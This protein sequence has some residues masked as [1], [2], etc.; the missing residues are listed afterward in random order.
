M[1]TL[2]YV[3]V[4]EFD[5]VLALDIPIER[6]CALFAALC[7]INTLY[8]IM[9]A[10]SGHIGTSFS[11]LDLMCWIFLN[12]LG[13]QRPREAHHND[14]FF[15][16]K[17]HDVPAKYSAL[18]GLRLLDFDLIHKL[19]RLGG[20]PGH[21]DISIPHMYTNTGSLGMGISKA[22]GMALARRLQGQPGRI[23][24]L[25]GDGELQEGQFWES[26]QPT[27]NQGL[28][29]ITVVVDH[30]K[31]QSDTWV[32][33]V[34]DLGALERKI[35]AF[36]WYVERC[37]GHD[38]TA[39]QRTFAQLNQITDRPKLLIA[40]TIKGKGVSFMEHTAMPPGD[41]RLYPYH[42][43]APDD[44][45]Y[46]RAAEEL[47]IGA[48]R[49][50]S[51][52][53]QPA[54][55]LE[56]VQQ[57]ARSS[58]NHLQRLVAAY[59]DALVKAAEHNPKLVALDADLARDTGLIP[60][61]ARFPERFFECGIAEQDMVSQAGGMALQGLLP[62]VHSFACFLSTRPNEQI[63]NNATE[64]TKIIY[65]GSLAG[66]IPG[67]PGHSH[68]SVRDISA[69][70][71]IPNLLLI[72]PSCEQEVALALDFCINR[73]AESCY[74]RL[75]SVPC[76]IPFSLPDDYELEYG[77]GIELTP[78]EDAL[79]FSYGPVMLAQAVY[80]ARQLAEEGIGLKVINLPWLNR[81]DLE[82]LQATLAGYRQV[83]TLDNHYINGGQGQFLASHIAQ[84]KLADPPRV[85][86]FG[87]QDI[88]VCGTNDEV[89]RA[90]RLD[91]QSLSEQIA[92]VLAE[93]KTR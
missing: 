41:D 56:A 11:S 30:N 64:L 32:A 9:R 85:H 59:A 90:H 28:H 24:V 6:R 86:Q 76:A 51:E 45:T 2:Y 21:P 55:T 17:G 5:R 93:R 4:D 58:G 43:G 77:R 91:A 63:Y 12:E 72:E 50:L 73:T 69:L 10:G 16:S 31:L 46:A 29:E 15:S 25:T 40:D 70:G 36:G 35:Q 7:R 37:D 23:L 3:P 52:M 87:L 19:R 78:G 57:P 13:Y 83:F 61:E 65:V 42:S 62:V 48:N 38:F 84:L 39:L 81:V 60:F 8:M 18:L 49:L 88:P 71:A 75:V 92:S 47:I 80:A 54:L 22:R 66:L 74:L 34:S 53:G 67:G 33:R 89:L 20:L 68:Q 26:L 44:A 79:L 82:W 14:I 1:T 27:A